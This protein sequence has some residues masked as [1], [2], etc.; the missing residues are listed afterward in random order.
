MKKKLVVIICA[1]ILLTGCS[2]FKK[3][4]SDIKKIYLNVLSNEITYIDEQ[5]NSKFISEYTNDEYGIDSYAIIDIN[6]DDVI[7]MAVK[8]IKTDSEDIYLLLHYYKNKVYCKTFN[9]VR[10]ITIS[11]TGYI[12]DFDID[13]LTYT[14]NKYTFEDGKY[15]STEAYSY[16]AEHTKC[17]IKG[18]DVNCEEFT[19]EYNNW[20]NEK[21]VNPEWKPY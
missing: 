13:T 17:R 3:D 9:D 20:L 2:W 14:W 6:E 1:A 21:I 12:T 19:D 15:K 18:K 11:D 8:L 16:N 7:D 10:G 5:K 4:N